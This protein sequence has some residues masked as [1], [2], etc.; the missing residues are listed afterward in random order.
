ML[1]V[2]RSAWALLKSED[3]QIIFYSQLIMGLRNIID[4]RV[5][6][7]CTNGKVIRWGKEFLSKL[8]DEETHAV[9][10]HEG[11]H[12]AHHHLWRMPISLKGNIAGDYE[13]NLIID[14]LAKQGLAIK[15]PKGAL[16]DQKYDGWAVEEIYHDLPDPITIVGVSIGDFEKPAGTGKGKEGEEGKADDLKEE[17]TRRLIQAAQVSKSLK[18][19]SVPA[20]IQRVIDERL[21]QRI[22]WKS[23]TSEFIRDII[24]VRNDWSRPNRRHAWQSVIYPSKREDLTCTVLSQRDTSG[25]VGNETLSIFNNLLEGLVA[26]LGCELILLDVDCTLQAE[27]HIE[28]GQQIPN[29]AKGGGGTSFIPTFERLKQLQEDGENIAGIVVLTDLQGEMPKPEDYPDLPVLWLSI[30][31]DIAPFG[32][33]VF[34]DG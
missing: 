34:V 25:S 24:S 6:T 28:A 11:L 2:D 17:W 29:T 5:P 13:I 31:K 9:L 3:P 4:E 8:T 20:D 14:K 19:G 23:I 16:L 33:T 7:A 10:I 32:R 15:L 12:C 26:E 21:A 27:Y 1:K 22:D 30:T 18:R